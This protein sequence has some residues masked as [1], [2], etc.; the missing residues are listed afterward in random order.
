MEYRPADFSYWDT[1]EHFTL[2]EA[3]WLWCDLEPPARGFEYMPAFGQGVKPHPLI[4]NLPAKGDRAARAM[5]QDATESETTNRLIWLTN[6]PDTRYLF[7][8]PYLRAWAENH[9]DYRP[10]F[11]FPEVGVIEL[12]RQQARPDTALTSPPA[13]PQHE[14]A[15]PAQGEP[16]PIPKH[17]TELQMHKRECQEIGKRLWIENPNSTKAAIIKH[18]DMC[19]YVKHY[20]GKNTLSNWLREVDPRPKESRRGRPKKI[21]V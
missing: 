18:P 2:T 3:A 11:L 4:P 13:A 10:R 6:Y 5:W 15:N 14:L 9:S 20:K 19:F 16:G 21:P 17:E 7:P 12:A 8:R 1:V